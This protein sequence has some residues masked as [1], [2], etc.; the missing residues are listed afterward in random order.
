[1]LTVVRHNDLHGLHVVAIS[2][3]YR[4]LVAT[5]FDEGE[6]VIVSLAHATG[7]TAYVT[8]SSPDGAIVEDWKAVT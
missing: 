3:T 7:S 1:M 6:P 2:H 4:P 5:A 8:V